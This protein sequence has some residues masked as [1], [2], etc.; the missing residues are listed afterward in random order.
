MIVAERF[1]NRLPAFDIAGDGTLSNR[2]VWAVLGTRVPDGICLDA[3]GAIW[4]SSLHDNKPVCI[5]VR[6]GGQVLQ[7]LE[8][9]GSCFACML[10]GE[11]RQT[12]FMMVADWH[13]AESIDDNLERLLNGPRTGQVLT[14]SALAP[15]VGWP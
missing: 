11:E 5:R 1:A 2:R 10:G 4:S 13:M 3:D 8:L 14:A 15:G 6:E 12:L 9:D 7:R